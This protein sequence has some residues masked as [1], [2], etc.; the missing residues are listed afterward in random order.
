M[1]KQKKEDL[2]KVLNDLLTKEQWDLIEKLKGHKVGITKT[3]RLNFLGKLLHKTR[4]ISTRKGIARWLQNWT[5]DK[6]GE[7]TELSSGKDCE[8]QGREMGQSG[9]D[10]RM[11]PKAR[12][13]FPFTPECKSGGLNIK[14]AIKQAIANLYPNT[15]W[16]VVWYDP[17]SQKDNRN[18]P[19]VIID[20]ERFF[21]LYS[22]DWIK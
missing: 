5:A 14:S 7:V 17:N 15:D 12:V 8:L 21:Q 6:I 20:G 11:S 10:V 9:P 22:K 1:T 19:V 4:K 2:L 18:Q 13:L 16:M 3:A